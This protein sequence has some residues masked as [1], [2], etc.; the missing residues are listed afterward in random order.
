[1]RTTVTLDGDTRLL[2]ERFMAERGLSFKEALN[3][4]VRRGLAHPAVEQLP[5]TRARSMGRPRVD[6]TKALALAGDLEDDAL[7]QKLVDGR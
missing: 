4:A 5:V 3:E 2:I 7:A 1:M 6:L